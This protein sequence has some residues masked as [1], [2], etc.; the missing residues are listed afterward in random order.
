MDI[1]NLKE[2][3][4]EMRDMYGEQWDSALIDS[5]SGLQH[6]IVSPVTESVIFRAESDSLHDSWLCD[7]LEAICPD[8]VLELIDRLEKAEAQLEALASQPSNT[9][10][11]V[12][13]F[14]HAASHVPFVASEFEWKFIRFTDLSKN[15]RMKCKI[16]WTDGY[17]SVVY[18]EE[19]APQLLA[20]WSFEVLE[21]KA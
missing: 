8:A 5:G 13:I 7:Y 16:A 18:D 4:Q 17:N 3:A 6:G 19:G 21:G 20:N 15:Q 9:G 14:T 11:I 10:D 1:K 2:M 12:A